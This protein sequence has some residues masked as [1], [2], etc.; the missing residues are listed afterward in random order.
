M[1]ISL[2]PQYRADTL[3]VVRSGDVLTISGEPYDFSSL[4]DGATIPAGTIPCKFI[5]GPVERIDGEINLTLLLPHGASPSQ[6]VA[7]PEPITVT[8]DGPVAIPHDPEPEDN[9]D[10]DA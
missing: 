5:V 1:R 7:Y 9:T 2:S 6:A 3:T 10:V 8:A 4:P